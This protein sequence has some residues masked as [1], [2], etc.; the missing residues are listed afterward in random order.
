MTPSGVAG[1]PADMSAHP[2]RRAAA[3]ALSLLA[4]ACLSTT[5]SS[6][7]VF[8]D[9]TGL[10]AP[11]THAATAPLSITVVVSSGGCR[12]FETLDAVREASRLTITAVGREDEGGA[13]TADVRTDRVV[14][15]AQPPFFDSLL[16]VARQPNGTETTRVVR[17]Q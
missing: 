1:Y 7:T 6:R 15:V 17:M 14:H 10:E 5:E 9:I 11:A 13:C 12:R 4:A 8:L 3:V 16:V 2:I